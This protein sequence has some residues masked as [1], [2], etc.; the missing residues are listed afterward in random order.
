MSSITDTLR[1]LE[2]GVFVITAS[3]ELASLVKAVDETGKPG[4]LTI[5]LAI[6]RA[7]STALSVTPK[8]SVKKPQDHAID[9]LLF[10]TTEG[11]LLTEDPHQR[12]LDL[13]AV[14]IPGA[15]RLTIQLKTA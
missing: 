4:K 14:E 1:Q 6:K 13:K 3:E 12:K 8:V 11:H 10:P 15:D 7:S 2:G 9:T 5:E